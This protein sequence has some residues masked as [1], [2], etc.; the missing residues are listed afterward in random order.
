MKNIREIVSNNIIELRK[1]NNLTQIKLAEKI[2]FS[3]KA[4]SRWEKG[5]VIP[6][7][8]TLQVLA[9]TFDVPIAT[10]LEEHHDE[11]K[12][13]IEK[14]NDL[15]SQILFV[16]EIWTIICVIYIYINV[17]YNQNPW[18]IFLSGIPISAA[19]LFFFSIKKSTIA[20]FVYA[21]VLTWSTL[22][23]IFIFMLPV[24]A[25]YIFIIGLPVQG[26]LI[27]KYLFKIKQK[28]ILSIKVLKKFKNNKK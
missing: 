2:N 14:R 8:E 25:W 24:I 23:C 6:D 11:E 4:I 28:N 5:E 1:K 27:L 22:I 20:K 9:D 7:I 3:D 15:L 19:I 18:K 26:I 16:F 21:T 13:S 10:L 17:A 12:E